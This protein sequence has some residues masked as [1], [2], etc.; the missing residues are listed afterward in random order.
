M[1]VY[2]IPLFPPILGSGWFLRDC[3]RKFG[4]ECW[5]VLE[6]EGFVCLIV[7]LLLRSWNTQ[8]YF[9]ESMLGTINSPLLSHDRAKVF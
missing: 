7:A 4:S 2:F 3:G 1:S 5:H 8:V 9:H 6:R